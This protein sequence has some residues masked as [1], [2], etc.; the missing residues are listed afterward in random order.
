MFLNSISLSFYSFLSFSIRSYHFIWHFGQFYDVYISDSAQNDISK[1]TKILTFAQ[2][3][4]FRFAVAFVQFCIL[5]D[6]VSDKVNEL[7]L[8]YEQPK[9][10]VYKPYTH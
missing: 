7:A 6:L 3:D 9:H 4:L 10:R 1:M 5:I 2:Y 8:H